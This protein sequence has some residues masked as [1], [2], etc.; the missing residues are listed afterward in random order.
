MDPVALDLIL[1]VGRRLNQM[2]SH[3]VYASRGALI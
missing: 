1:I 2:A 3:G